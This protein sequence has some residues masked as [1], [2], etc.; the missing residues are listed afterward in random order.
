MATSIATPAA[1]PAPAMDL[2]SAIDALPVI[3]DPPEAAPEAPPALETPAEEP[4]TP[5]EEAES[6]PLPEEDFDPDADEIKPDRVSADGKE[7]HFRAAKAKTMLQA[8][9]FQRQVQQAI[10]NAN[11]DQLKQNYDRVTGLDQLLSDYDS[12]DPTKVAQAAQAFLGTA[13]NPQSV[14]FFADHVMQTVARTQPQ[15]FAQIE[16]KV[17]NGLISRL[18]SDAQRTGDDGLMKL[19]QNLDFKHTGKFRNADQVAQRDPI[20]EERTRFEQERSDFYRIR[21]QE[22][23]Q[24]VEQEVQSAQQASDAA[25]DEE[26]GKV[27]TPQIVESFK[28]VPGGEMI[29]RHITRDLRDAVSE[30]RKANPTWEKQYQLAVGRLRQNPSAQAKEQV[31]TMMRQF[32]APYISRGKAM[33][34]TATE[35]YLSDSAAA[36]AKQQQIEQRKEPNSPGAPVRRPGLSQQLKDAK[37]SGKSLESVLNEVFA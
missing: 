16:A 7:Y 9:D 2:D 33:V 36:H 1:A 37:A 28:A 29:V 19:A 13:Q 11:L 23:Q 30:A 15:V 27:V 35:R 18:Y 12:G 14:G 31:V 32:A 4:P 10:P 3:A 6:E 20:A 17:T 25:V 5:P 21:Q 34:K 8:L 26:I 22:T 24:R